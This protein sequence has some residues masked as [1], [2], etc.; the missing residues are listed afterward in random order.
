MYATKL[1]LG[2]LCTTLRLMHALHRPC[3]PFPLLS[4]RS[5]SPFA[6]LL[7]AWCLF[8]HMQMLWGLGAT[9]ALLGELGKGMAASTCAV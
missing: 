4:Y 3:Q 5:R 2:L 9:T 1:L 6:W 8:R 7:T